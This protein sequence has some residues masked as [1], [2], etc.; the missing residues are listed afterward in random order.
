M[1]HQGFPWVFH[2]CCPATKHPNDIPWSS[3][4]WSHCLWECTQLWE[5]ARSRSGSCHQLAHQLAKARCPEASWRSAVC[6]QGCANDPAGKPQRLHLSHRSAL[7]SVCEAWQ[8]VGIACSSKPLKHF[9]IDRPVAA[10]KTLVG[11][12]SANENL[13]T[14]LSHRKH[15]T[16]PQS[17]CYASS[18]QDLPHHVLAKPH[19]WCLPES[20]SRA[21]TEAPPPHPHSTWWSRLGHSCPKLEEPDLPSPR[22]DHLAGQPWNTLAS[23]SVPQGAATQHC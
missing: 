12:G 21:S 15:C 19:Q 7:R 10:W 6:S 5:S 4:F 20:Y 23:A 2:T 18:D 1:D 16:M 9:P 13:A 3:P 11:N 22:T 8:S 17:K 14:V